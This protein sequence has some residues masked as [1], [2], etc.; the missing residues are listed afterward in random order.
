MFHIE[1]I[2]WLP[3]SKNLTTLAIRDKNQE[4]NNQDNRD[5]ESRISDE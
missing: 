5:E 1:M 2:A 3:T 4:S